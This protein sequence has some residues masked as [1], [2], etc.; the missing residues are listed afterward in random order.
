MKMLGGRQNWFVWFVWSNQ[1]TATYPQGE[2]LMRGIEQ[3]LTKNTFKLKP[4]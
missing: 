1:S 4:G 2:H 3:K